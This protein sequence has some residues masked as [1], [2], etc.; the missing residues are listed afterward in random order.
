MKGTFDASA[1]QFDQDIVMSLP[2]FLKG[3]PRLFDTVDGMYPDITKHDF[4]I[5]SSVR[6]HELPSCS[7]SRLDILRDSERVYDTMWYYFA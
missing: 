2:H 5:S 3:D 4:E 6:F 1:C 7:V